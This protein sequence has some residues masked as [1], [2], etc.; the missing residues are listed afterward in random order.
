MLRKT[1]KILTISLLLL[2]L[3][4]SVYAWFVFSK[5][6]PIGE[7]RI[8]ELVVQI[9]KDGESFQNVSLETLMYIDLQKDLVEDKTNTF[10]DVSTSLMFE[11]EALINS[12]PVRN[13]IDFSFPDGQDPLLYLIIY[14]GINLDATHEK[15]TSYHNF[16]LSLVS[17]NEDDPN[18]FLNAIENYN[19]STLEFISELI[20]EPNDII[21]IQIIFWGL[22][23][24]LSLPASYLDLDYTFGIV[25]NSVQANQGA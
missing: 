2:T 7:F 16:I 1:K 23:D 8:G 9:T 5:S 17:E 25:I 11:I 10:D 15:L 4:T 20:L 14:E 12:Y 13:I 18:A 22:Y 19:T 3:I 6:S 21:S 24:T